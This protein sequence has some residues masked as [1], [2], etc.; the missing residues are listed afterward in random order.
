MSG[1]SDA[2]NWGTTALPHLRQRRF[3]PAT[4]AP[5]AMET[6]NLDSALV[7][8]IWQSYPFK[9]QG[10]HHRHGQCG[11]GHPIP[12]HVQLPPHGSGV[13]SAPAR[14]NDLGQHAGE[15]RTADWGRCMEK[16][17]P[18]MRNWDWRFSPSWARPKLGDGAVVCTASVRVQSSSAPGPVWSTE[19]SSRLPTM[20]V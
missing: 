19:C 13:L 12:I 20:R 7:G 10:P 9:Q 15:W 18:D 8:E 5:V 6:R 1:F 3:L 14:R 2:D 11:V 16:S 4:T 17:P